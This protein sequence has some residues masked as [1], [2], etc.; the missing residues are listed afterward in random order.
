[1]KKS[2]ERKKSVVRIEKKCV[3]SPDLYLFKLNMKEEI[4]F[5]SL[6]QSMNLLF[7]KYSNEE[8]LL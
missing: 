4:F 1:M 5:Y 2:I 7:R 6:F 8:S 3:S